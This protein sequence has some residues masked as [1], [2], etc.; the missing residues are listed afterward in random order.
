MTKLLALTIVGAV[1][2]AAPTPLPQA[3]SVQPPF[4]NAKVEQRSATLSFQRGTSRT[5]EVD[6]T[7]QPSELAAQPMGRQ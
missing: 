1:L 4:Q 5:G 3:G 6:D 7:P 2:T